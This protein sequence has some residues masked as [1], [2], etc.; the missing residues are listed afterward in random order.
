M[1]DSR[2]CLDVILTATIPEYVEGMKAANVLN[3][4]KVKNFEK[5][6]DGKIV[7]VRVKDQ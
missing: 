5:N 1:D 4:A 2:L 3:Y 6:E 7:G